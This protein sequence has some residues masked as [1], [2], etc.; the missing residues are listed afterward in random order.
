MIEQVSPRSSFLREKHNR[1]NNIQPSVYKVQD[2]APRYGSLGSVSVKH[3]R[4]KEVPKE[5]LTPRSSFL[6]EKHNRENNI[7]SSV[8]KVQDRAP[9]YGSLGSVSVK[10]R[11]EKEVPKE[12][13]TP[14][15][16]FLR[17]KYNRENKVRGTAPG[18]GRL[19]SLPATGGYEKVKVKHIRENE[20][21]TQVLTEVLS[22]VLPPGSSFLR[23]KSNSKSFIG[24]GIGQGIGQA[25]LQSAKELVEGSTTPGIREVATVV[26]ILVNLIADKQDNVKSTEASLRRCRSIIT[27]LN[28]ASKLIGKGGETTGRAERILMEDVYDAIFDIVELIKMYRSKNRISQLMMSTLFKKRQEEM[29]AV[30]DSAIIGLQLGLHVQVGTDVK[31]LKGVCQDYMGEYA[32][33]S[34]AESRK[35]RRQRKLDQLE[36]P[37]DHL[38]I[39]EELIGKGG[40]GDVFLADYNGRNAAAKVIS[41]N[42]GDDSQR[43]SFML[44]LGIMNRLRSPYTVNVYG[45][46]TSLSNKLVI[47]M[48]LLPGGDLRTLL[49]SGDQIT[50]ER[51]RQLIRDICSGM[52]FLH[53]N[54]TIHG[55]VKSANILLDGN[56][57]AKIADFGTAKWANHTMS[58][59]LATFTNSLNTQMSL[60]WSAPE[61][62]DSTGSTYASDV[63]SFGVVVWE[64]ISRELPWSDV[65][66][67]RDIYISVVIKGLRLVFPED[68]PTEISNMAELCW[69]GE[70]SDRPTFD[71]LLENMKSNG[72]K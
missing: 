32:S 19:G 62:L 28:R 22:E 39:T 37:A 5:V 10:H 47:V 72:W 67:P 66:H 24:S 36:I 64:I 6:R 38:V 20:V 15:S 3:R 23:E 25:I 57:R 43:K 44:E 9:R 55:D 41:I 33:K 58:T 7:Q 51:S 70:A 56:G 35:T 46:V 21:P 1:E 60:A 61:V 52:A 68:S 71:F 17:E 27:M 13:L 2:R 29:G 50:G 4:E 42:L 12:V 34:L 8:Y 16:A 49:K 26:S 40:F 65:Q 18:F 48:E 63:Y 14:R 30:V 53:T 59:G 31:E 69:S 11:R 45:A 54:K